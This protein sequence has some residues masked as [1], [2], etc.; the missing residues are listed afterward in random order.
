MAAESGRLNYKN[1]AM[2]K[3]NNGEVSAKELL[4]QP[5]V[6]FC[7]N[8]EWPWQIRELENKIFLLRFLP[9]KNVEDLIEFHAFNLPIDG[10]S[11]KI[12]TWEGMLDEFGE[13]KE[14]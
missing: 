8:K 1:C 12:F 7:K 13:L 4:I 3:V 11:V 2:L 10:V 9:W 6:I 5:N 14:A